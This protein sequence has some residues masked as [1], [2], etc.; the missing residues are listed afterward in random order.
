MQ[1]FYCTIECS[2]FDLEIESLTVGA[3]NADISPRAIQWYRT[4]T[5]M[6]QGVWWYDA[7]FLWHCSPH[8]T[9]GCGSKILAQHSVKRVTPWAL[10]ECWSHCSLSL[11][12]VVQLGACKQVF[13]FLHRFVLR[14]FICIHLQ[15]NL[16]CIQGFLAEIFPQPALIEAHVCVKSCDYFVL[17]LFCLICF[18]IQHQPFKTRLLLCT[19]AR[20]SSHTF[21][22]PEHFLETYTVWPLPRNLCQ[23]HWPVSE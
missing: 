3:S 12:L 22:I 2:R 19:V 4:G 15:P 6:Q 9:A 20:R 16:F 7:L 21:D 11:I 13:L 8:G 23:L 1:F 14:V 5:V 10:V 17:Y 18:S